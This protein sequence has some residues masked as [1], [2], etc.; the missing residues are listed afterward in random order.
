MPSFE[1]IRQSLS[2]SASGA[3]EKAKSSMGLTDP[4]EQKQPDRLDELSEMCPKLSFQQVNAL[5]HRISQCRRL[6]HSLYISV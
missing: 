2:Q 5:L 1:E 6:A 4:E 3:M